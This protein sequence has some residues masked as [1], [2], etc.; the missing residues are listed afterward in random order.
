[1]LSR[2]IASWK[3]MLLYYGMSKK[4]L[5]SIATQQHVSNEFL[6]RD[7]LTAEI[8]LEIVDQ[9]QLLLDREATHDR[10]KY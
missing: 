10:L 3:Y 7:T 1:M 5:I 9:L 6:D 4:I 2:H 8:V